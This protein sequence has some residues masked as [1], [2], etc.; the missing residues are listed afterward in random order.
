MLNQTQI[1]LSVSLGVSLDFFLLFN[2]VTVGV[3]IGGLHDF[4]SKGLSDI[5]S[6]LET[7]V[8]GVLS[9]QVD[10]LVDSSEGRYINSLSLDISSFSDSG[11]VFSGT[12]ISNSVEKNLKRILSSL[13]MDDLK[14]L[15]KNSYGPSL[16]TSVSA[17]EAKRTNDSL[18]NRATGL[19]ESLQLVSASSVGQKH[20]GLGSGNSDVVGKGWILNFEFIV[21]PLGEQLGF[22]GESAFLNCLAYSSLVVR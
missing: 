15:F 9:N 12:A 13:E 22:G 20:S 7:L 1:S 8:S 10:G 5:L 11:R 17:V 18:S 14:G 16:L 3:V 19:L 2:T 6:V 4:I 21:T